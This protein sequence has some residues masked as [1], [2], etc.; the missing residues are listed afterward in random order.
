LTPELSLFGNIGWGQIT[1]QPGMYMLTDSNDFVR[2][3]TEN[4]WKFDLGLR[5][6]IERWG[7]VTV[8]GFFVHQDNTAIV[9]ND[10]NTVDGDLVAIFEEADRK[11]Y[12]VEV[13]FRSRRFENGLQFFVNATAM[14]TERTFDGDWEEDEEVPNF[15]VG[16]GFSY[17]LDKFEIA[18]FARHLNEYE[19]E[20]FL[21]GGSDPVPL[22]DFTEI[23]GILRYHWSPTTE[24]FVQVDNITDDEYSTVA[25]YPNDG[26]HIFGGVV[27]RF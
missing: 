4:R 14:E 24:L 6:E 18:L 13:E 8:T 2:P 27:K 26:T 11:N 7:Q 10:V 23:N 16:G 20:R 21:P 5:R 12:G 1:A 15:I 9:V 25:G 19:N 22:G 17:L 3:D